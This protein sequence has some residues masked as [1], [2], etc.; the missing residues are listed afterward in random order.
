MKYYASRLLPFYIS[1]AVVVGV[2]IG[3][4]YATHFSG[5]RISFHQH[6]EQ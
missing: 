6:L 1:V 4:F 2:L 5:N 3:S